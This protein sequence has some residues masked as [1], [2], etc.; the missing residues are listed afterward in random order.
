[1]ENSPNG[2]PHQSAVRSDPSAGGD[3]RKLAISLVHAQHVY[4]GL[5]PDPMSA[6]IVEFSIYLDALASLESLAFVQPTPDWAEFVNHCRS[7]TGG[8][9][10]LNVFYDVVYGPVSNQ[11]GESISHHEQLSFIQIIPYYCSRWWTS[12]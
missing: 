8:H 4:N 9:R 6:A 1:M 12:T 10:G 3:L 2:V 7:P 11:R 5:V